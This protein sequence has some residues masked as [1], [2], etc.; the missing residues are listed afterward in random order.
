MDIQVEKQ[1]GEDQEAAVRRLTKLAQKAGYN[2]VS[3]KTESA[4]HW[5]AQYYDPIP[6]ATKK[7]KK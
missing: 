1:K 6:K 2:K 3:I 4:T 5:G 7:G